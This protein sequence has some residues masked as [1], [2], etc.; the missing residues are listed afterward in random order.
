[1]AGQISIFPAQQVNTTGLATASN[2][3]LEIAA[4][5]SID[6]KL[7]SPLSVTASSLP[8]PA[9]ASTSALQTTGNASLASIDT[10][11]TSPLTTK[12]TDGAGIVNTKQIGTAITSSD[13]GLITNTVIHGLTTGGGSGYVDVKVTPSG[14]LVAD[15]T[16]SSSAL[17]TGAAT[18]ATLSS[19]NSKVTAVNT[20][21]VVISSS[22]LPTGAATETTLSS[23]NTKI[24]SNL[25]VTSTRLLVDGSGVTQPTSEVTSS[26]GT[27]TSVSGSASSVTILASNANR[28]NATFYNDS[29][30]T[31]YL[32]LTSSAASTTAYTIQL[33][34]N[35]YY[36]LPIGKIYTGTIT[37]IWSS[38][39]GAVRVTELS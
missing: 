34:S 13:I 31:L 36:E 18:E 14:A 27:I 26:T 32:A 5:N 39:T 19:L 28:K 10:K 29:S 2:Q 21:A 15:V 16:V 25:T 11:L 9:G 1:M 12:I 20:G 8:L 33:P 6:T 4:L 24:P 38:A 30:A 3:V 37:G 23:I 35:G 17:P 7:T 22:A